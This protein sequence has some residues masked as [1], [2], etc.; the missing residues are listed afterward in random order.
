MLTDEDLHCLFLWYDV[1]MDAEM[2][3]ERSMSEV[4]K[5][6]KRDSRVDRPDSCPAVIYI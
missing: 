2:D 4:Q 6:A 1:A 3:Q 5:V